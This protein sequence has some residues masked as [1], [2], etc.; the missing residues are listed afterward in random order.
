MKSSSAAIL[1]PSRA[2]AQPC[3]CY[4]H[5][6]EHMLSYQWKS[7]FRLSSTRGTLT[8]SLHDLLEVLVAH[9]LPAPVVICW[10]FDRCVEM[11]AVCV[12]LGWFVRVKRERIRR[13]GPFIFTMFV[14][15]CGRVPKDRV[16]MIIAWPQRLSVCVRVCVW[17]CMNLVHSE[18]DTQFQP[19][20]G[21]V[22]GKKTPFWA[23]GV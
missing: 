6:S 15:A 21:K 19:I 23:A 17:M 8:E 7:S 9:H 12:C 13:P 10:H 1:C 18:H 11:V 14:H 2:L 3:C 16:Q 4:L 22:G 5:P 20:A